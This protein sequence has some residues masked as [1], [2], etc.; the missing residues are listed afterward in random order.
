MNACASSAISGVAVL[1]VPIAQT[2]SYAI[3]S[4]SCVAGRERDRLDLDLEHELGVPGLALLERLADAGDHAEPRFER[5][6]RAARDHLVGLAE[7]L[8]PLRVAD[9]RALRPR[10]R[11]ASP[12]RPRRCRGRSAPSA[13]SGRRSSGR[14]RRPRRARRTAGRR[15]RRRRRGGLEAV[16]ERT[17][18]GRALE[19]LPVAG[20]QHPVNSPGS[21]RRPGAPCPR[22]ARAT[23]RR[24]SRPTR[25]RR[26]GRAR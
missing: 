6:P 21:R 2:G 16:E 12:A 10:A 4:R 13:R 19:H 22:A 8:A 7:E 9:E 5:G 24:R 23:R 18:L 25:S 15:R 26:R 14:S 1:P 20:D 17:R 11:A 3:T